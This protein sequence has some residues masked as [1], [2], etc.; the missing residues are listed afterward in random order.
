MIKE[1]S[2]SSYVFPVRDGRIAILKYGEN[3]YGPIGGRV[4]DG[5][6]FITALRRELAEEL[7][8]DVAKLADVA[9]E[10]PAPY[11]FRHTSPERIQKRG[12][13]AEEHHF[14]IAP[15]PDGMEL[16]FC[17]DRPEQISVVWLTPEELLRPS[18][19]PFADMRE[20][21][22]KHLFPAIKEA[23]KIVLG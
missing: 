17:E 19:A 15:V 2:F 23:T 18:V 12:A 6:D 22:E 16:K 11:C 7:G 14:F 8:P 21:Y 5:E 13:K 9:V 1:L 10:L 4:D 20:F 3:G